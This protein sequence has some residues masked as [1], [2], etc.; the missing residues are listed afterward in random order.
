LHHSWAK[1][2]LSEAEAPFVRT[3]VILASLDHHSGFNLKEIVAEGIGEEEIQWVMS[4]GSFHLRS[5]YDAC[6]ESHPLPPPDRRPFL[7]GITR[8][9]ALARESSSLSPLFIYRPPSFLFHLGE[10]EL[11][12][13]AL[14]GETDDGLAEK[15]HISLS[16]VKKRWN[17]IYERVGA[18][19]PELLPNDDNN[20]KRGLQKRHL[21]LSYLRHHPEEL[22][23]FEPRLSC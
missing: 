2:L 6:Y 16:A 14:V 13:Q 10:Q 7:V 12:R 18:R 22:R 5:T 19:E 17:A 8:A 3:Q 9:E 11:L 20:Q 15:L 21:L 4:G 1:E 23:P